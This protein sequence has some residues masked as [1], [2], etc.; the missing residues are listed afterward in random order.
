MQDTLNHLSGGAWAL[1][2]G[3]LFL[4]VVWQSRRDREKK[5]RGSGGVAGQ[6]VFVSRSGGMDTGKKRITI[7]QRVLLVLFAIAVFF[8]LAYISDTYLK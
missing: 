3:V 1:I 7:G 6:W 5:R 2:L 8:V 4:L